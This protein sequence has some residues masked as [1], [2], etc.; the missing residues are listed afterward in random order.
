MGTIGR[1][2]GGYFDA[3]QQRAQVP[4]AESTGGESGRKPEATEEKT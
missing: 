1:Y 2:V 4:V 3:Q